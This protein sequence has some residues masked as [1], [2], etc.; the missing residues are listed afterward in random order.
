MND[1]F[2]VNIN[3]MDEAGDT[4]QDSLRV[5]KRHKI[6]PSLAEGSKPKGNPTA[7]T[8]QTYVR[9]NESANLLASKGYD[10]TFLDEMKDGNGYGISKKSNPDFLIEEKVFDCYA[11]GAGTSTKTIIREIAHKTKEQAPNIVLNLDDYAGNVDELIDLLK[12]KA[13]PKGDLKRLDELKIIKN[14]TI[15]DIFD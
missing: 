13:N 15:I 6:K 9:Q 3:L 2:R 7:E 8:K 10:V 5:G 1:D 12:R 4:L 11:P 14:G